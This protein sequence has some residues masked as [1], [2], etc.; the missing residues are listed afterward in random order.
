LK[1]ENKR[2]QNWGEMKIVDEETTKR[3]E[4]EFV[5][6]IEEALDIDKVKLLMQSEI[7]K[8]QE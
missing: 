5:G 6:K 2:Y 1:E 4:E 7:E 8:K 3:L